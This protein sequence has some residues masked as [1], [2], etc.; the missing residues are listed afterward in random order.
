MVNIVLRNKK[1]KSESLL[2]AGLV[3]EA[4]VSYKGGYIGNTKKRGYVS[5]LEYY[6]KVSP[7]LNELSRLL[8]GWCERRTSSLT[9]GEAVYSISRSYSFQAVCSL[10]LIATSSLTGRR[11][12]AIEFL[13]L[14]C[15]WTLL[16]L[17]I[18]F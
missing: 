12:R 6:L 8:S 1:P 4:L 7:Q 5:M 13:Y 3:P 15:R 10:C 2:C 17:P 14:Y 18:L 11:I 9:S 16:F